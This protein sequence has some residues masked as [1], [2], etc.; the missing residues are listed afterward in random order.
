MRKQ[1][2]RNRILS[3][4][5]YMLAAAVCVFALSITASA[6][7]DG[8]T[9]DEFNISDESSGISLTEL[10]S[11][12]TLETGTLVVSCNDFSVKIYSTA[13]EA[14]SGGDNCEESSDTEF[15]AGRDYTIYSVSDTL[16]VLYDKE[17]SFENRYGVTLNEIRV[18]DTITGET[19]IRT[20]IDEDITV[21]IAGGST[22]SGEYYTVGEGNTARVTAVGETTVTLEYISGG[23]DNNLTNSVVTIN[24]EAQTVTV[25]IGEET[26]PADEYDVFYYIYEQTEGGE[27]I[28]RCGEEF[29]TEDGQYIAAAIAKESS[30][31]IGEKRSEP[32]TIGEEPEQEHDPDLILEVG[33]TGTLTAPEDL[34]EGYSWVSGDPQVAIVDQ[35]GVVTAT[36]EGTAP[37]GFVLENT[38]GES[39]DQDVYPTIFYVKVIPG[40]E[41]E[42]SDYALLTADDFDKNDT[43][44]EFASKVVVQTITADEINNSLEGLEKAGLV[45]VI[46]KVA[47]D[48]ESG[49]YYCTVLNGKVLESAASEGLAPA[50]YAESLSYGNKFYYVPGSVTPISDP[51]NLENATITVNTS[52]QTVNVSINGKAVPASAYNLY[53]FIST[54]I[55]GGE[56]VDRVGT[57]FPTEPGTYFAAITAVQ[58]AG[59]TGELRGESFTVTAPASDDT[60]EAS[61][62]TPTDSTSAE[63][64]DTSDTS[65]TSGTA[66]ETETPAETPA[67]TDT[68][69]ETPAET[70]TTAETPAETAAEEPAAEEEEEFTGKQ[71]LDES[72]V[73]DEGG[74]A[75]DDPDLDLTAEIQKT[76][77]DG[78]LE[79]TTDEE[80]NLGG[81]S[82]RDD[83]D[84]IQQAV[85]TP[86]ERR[87]AARNGLKISIALEVSEIEPEQS[88]KTAIENALS[89]LTALAAGAGETDSTVSKPKIGFYFDASVLK[90][91]GSGASEKVHETR[92]LITVA[93]AIPK[94]Y[95]NTDPTVERTYSIARLHEGV[96]TFLPCKF[97]PAL[98]TVAFMSDGFSTYAL[99]FMDKPIEVSDEKEEISSTDGTA[100]TVE[101]AGT[102]EQTENSETSAAEKNDT[103]PA[104]LISGTVRN[105]ATGTANDGLTLMLAFGAVAL[106]TAAKKKNNDK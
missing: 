90:K 44:A 43:T 7:S 83:A 85:L 99:I 11:G 34:P 68:T 62:T 94:A 46:Y 47:P 82:L 100:E 2:R 16:L 8:S 1:T 12:G 30:T 15:T 89:E 77:T 71:Q 52:A 66:A 103:P 51:Y 73:A 19:E 56:R 91:A 76:S 75:E 10:V 28:E 29:P 53:F 24:V 39:T 38:D 80:S 60:S 5:M 86:E 79:N 72:V 49:I 33:E 57:T 3:V 63:T 26:V 70:D 95:I 88:E 96:V 25:T 61:E 78:T 105:P 92:G 97:S 93:F 48:E 9:E 35:N 67:E 6:V 74:S 50:W 31:Y 40:A 59:Y 32:F 18:G 58:G 22:F 87:A 102:A 14:A 4:F 54:P 64:S 20:G 21:T 104:V 23:D 41:P 27:N 84:Y 36:G 13:E 69:A 101:A 65:D 42:Y 17:T 106:L 37:I 81:A 45:Y 98:G 55:E